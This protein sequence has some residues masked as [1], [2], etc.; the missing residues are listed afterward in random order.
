[1]GHAR[2]LVV[3]LALVGVSLSPALASARAE[4]AADW[5]ANHFCFAAGHEQPEETPGGY[6]FGVRMQSYLEDCRGEIILP[7]DE[8]P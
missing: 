6:R 2:L 7:T 1:M 8:Y 4:V 5:G 3:S